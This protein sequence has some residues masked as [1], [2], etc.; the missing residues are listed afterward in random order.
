MNTKVYVI[1]FSLFLAACGGGSSDTGVTEKETTC[2]DSGVPGVWHGTNTA[3]FGSYNYSIQFN[4]DGTGGMLTFAAGPGVT[5][6]MSAA[7]TVAFRTNQAEDTYLHYTGT[8]SCNRIVGVYAKQF[9]GDTVAAP[10]GTFV[11]TRSD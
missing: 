8:V 6:S 5:W 4:A 1:L 11:L 3:S 10:H 2:A 7:N 9:F